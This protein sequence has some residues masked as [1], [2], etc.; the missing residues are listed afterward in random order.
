MA[1]KS[2]SRFDGATFSTTVH[3]CSSCGVVSCHKT[4][5]ESHLRTNCP[6]ATIESEKC[7]LVCRAL[8]GSPASTTPTS[9]RKRVSESAGHLYQAVGDG[10]LRGSKRP[11]IEDFEADFDADLQTPEPKGTPEEPKTGYVYLVESSSVACK[12]IGRWTG[13]LDALKARYATYYPEPAI[14]AVATCRPRAVER[15]VKAALREE[16]LMLYADRKRELVK[17]LPAAREVFCAACSCKN[18]THT[19]TELSSSRKSVLSSEA[20]K[21]GDGRREAR[22]ET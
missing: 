3:R 12:K 14:L 4:N 9:P 15:A 19:A 8:G 18:R 20:G 13:T 10:T 5:V 11:R 16:G 17:P 6:G 22:W 21:M 7:E 2:A 1:T